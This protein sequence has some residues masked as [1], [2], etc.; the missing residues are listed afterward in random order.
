MVIPAPEVPARPARPEEIP[1]GAKTVINRLKKY[2]W[3][4]EALYARGP[5]LNPQS[6]EPDEL[7][8][9]SVLVRARRGAQQLAAMWVLRPGLKGASFKLQF[10]YAKPTPPGQCVGRIDSK[11]LKTIT[12][13]EP[14]P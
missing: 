12:E 3:T 14:T 13:S 6:M 8:A 4:N 9:E 5:W 7:Q 10:A 1:G 11:Q 2:G